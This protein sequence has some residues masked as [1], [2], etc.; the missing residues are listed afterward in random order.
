MATYDI[1]HIK[2][3]P[4][5]WLNHQIFTRLP[6][7]IIRKSVEVLIENTMIPYPKSVTEERIMTVVYERLSRNAKS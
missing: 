5:S 1:K 3:T 2:H 4:F 6:S 7:C